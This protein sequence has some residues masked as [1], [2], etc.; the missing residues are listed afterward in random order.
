MGYL[1]YKPADKPLT[2]A[3]ITDSV[4]TSAKIVDGTIANADINSS[5]AIAYS[6]LS[7]ANSVALT[8]LSATGTK[9]STTFLRGDNTFATAG[10]A[11]GQVIQVLSA[12][13]STQRSTTST[14][15]VTGS[16]TLSVTITPS[17]SS[18]KIFIVATYNCAVYDQGW[19]TLYRGSTNLGKAG[20]QGGMQNEIGDG[21]TR[22]HSGCLSYLDSPSTTSATT[23]QVYFHCAS[24]AG[25]DAYL[26][27]QG[28]TGSITCL[29]I[30][31]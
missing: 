13:D 25:Y 2:S 14:S 15:F 7:L 28:R 3:D 24:G 11:A 31:G 27:W 6:K 8:D 9:D 4:I 29:E 17:S 22:A 5:A 23:Y 16:N 19:F 26:N 18:N 20:N 10:A 1:G 12:T 30:K 21:S